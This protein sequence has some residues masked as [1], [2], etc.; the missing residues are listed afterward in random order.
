M[1]RLV[2]YLERVPR[3]RVFLTCGE[4][5]YTFGSVLDICSDFRLKYSFLLGQ[6]CSIISNDRETLALYLPAIDSLCQNIFLQPNDIK[7]NINELYVSGNI[8]YVITLSNGDV[9]SVVE[10]ENNYSCKDN[11]LYMLATSGTTGVP[12]LAAYTLNKLLSS[13]IIDV[14]KGKEFVWGLTYDI[15]RFSGLQVY[16]QAI[17]SGSNLVIS[18]SNNVKEIVHDF[19]KKSVNALSATPSFWRMFLMEPMH[20]NIIFKRIT[21]GGEI[22]S[23]SILS[24]LSREYPLAVISHI[25]ASTEAGVGFSIKD[26]LEGFPICYLENSSSIRCQLKVKDGV[27]WIKNPNGCSQL[28]KGVLVI[29]EYGFV[30]TGDL[31]EILDNRVI[32]LGRESGSINIG[33]NKVMP[34]KVETILESHPAVAMAKVFPKKSSLLGSLISSE[35][36]LYGDNFNVSEKDLKKDIIFF[37]KKYLL[38][39]EV[40]AFIKFVENIETNVTGKKVRNI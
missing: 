4:L 25:Y 12:K 39:F 27:L 26:K 31:V 33:G 2:D 17:A 18:K 21:L 10:Y 36:I 23:Q 9:S 8:N 11:K 40:P 24:S 13:S 7:N 16:L 38:P 37:C 5:K 28:L 32:F 30:N 35:V 22:S 1:M 29:D 20:S 15:N 19:I 6:N 3:D 14:K 34:E